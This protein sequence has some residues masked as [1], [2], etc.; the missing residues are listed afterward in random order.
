MK[1][2]EG[3]VRLLMYHSA[4]TSAPSRYR[5]C[6]PSVS[7]YS[8]TPVFSPCKYSSLLTT[9]PLSH[10]RYHRFVLQYSCIIGVLHQCTH[11]TPARSSDCT[12]APSSHCT[13]V[14]STH[15]TTAPSTHCT[16]GP[17]SH[18]ITAPSSHCTTAPSFHCTTAPSSSHCTTS[19]YNS[20]ILYMICHAPVS[21]LI[22][23]IKGFL[24]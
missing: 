14:P 9:V 16:T 12:T 18:C 24:Q 21:F 22:Q 13:T 7:R 17:S 1:G 15:C 19:Q 5:L 23:D 20:T 8:N 10:L 3:W 4:A 11:G 2:G 6:V